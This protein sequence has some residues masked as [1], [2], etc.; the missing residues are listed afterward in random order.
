MTAYPARQVKKRD[1]L[2]SA[3]QLRSP[4]LGGQSAFA[5]HP[6]IESDPEAPNAKQTERLL[7]SL[8]APPGADKVTPCPARC[9]ACPYS[10]GWPALPCIDNP[11]AS[12]SLMSGLSAPVCGVSHPVSLTS[13]ETLGLAGVTQKPAMLPF[14]PQGGDG[15]SFETAQASSTDGAFF[16]LPVTPAIKNPARGGALREGVYTNGETNRESSTSD[17]GTRLR[18]PP[19]KSSI[20]QLL[21]GVNHLIAMSGKA[22]PRNPSQCRYGPRRQ[23]DP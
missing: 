6:V 7:E 18:S 13:G 15:L 20:S 19:S 10:M 17:S 1:V 23:A 16:M 3:A 2:W 8:A 4:D 21:P 11:S 5:R 22:L 14:N 12:G 9:P